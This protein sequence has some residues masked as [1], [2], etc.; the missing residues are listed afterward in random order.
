MRLLFDGEIR[1][2]YRFLYLQPQESIPDLRSAV[3][4]QTNG[5]C[6]AAHPGVLSM[7]TGLHTGNVPVRVEAHDQEPALGSDWEEVVEVPFAIAAEEYCLSAF[8][9]GE[10]LVM[11]VPGSYRARWHASGMDPAREADVRMNDEPA[12]DRYLLQLWP[13]PPAADLIVR[14]SSDAAAS[15]HAVARETPPPP[16]PDEVAARLVVEQEERLRQEQSWRDAEEARRWGG[17]APTPQLLAMGSQAAQVAEVDRDLADA[18]A[19]MPGERQRSVA[20]WAARRACE[21]AGIAHL[22]WVRAGL[23]AT[24]RGAPLPA[25][26]QDWSSAWDRLHPLAPGATRQLSASITFVGLGGA[27]PTRIDPGSLAICAVI[28]AGESDAGVAVM[29]AVDAFASAF[30]D[31]DSGLREVA[32]YLAG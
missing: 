11:P 31:R 30:E 8:D 3:G 16:S 26:W 21:H 23:A 5:L 14:Q 20:V 15:W 24:E 29:T 9:T 18:L 19:A 4:G 10:D 13:A 27:P 1:V 25:P 17:R 28:A 2:H 6:G 32:A 22:D 12:I 7:V